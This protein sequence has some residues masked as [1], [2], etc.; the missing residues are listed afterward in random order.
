VSGFVDRWWRSGD[1]LRLHAR[2]YAAAG[3][4]ARLPVICLHGLTRNARDFEDLAPWIAASGRRV[5]ALDVRGRGLSDR[6][7]DPATYTLMVYAE[8]V[9]RLCL[10][11]GIGRSLF[12][13]TSMG[14]MITMVL[15]H[16]AP[17]LVGGAVLND[18]GP[19]IGVMGI[20]RIFSYAGKTPEVRTWADAAAYASMTNHTAF[21]RYGEADWLSFARRIFREQ[22]GAPVLDYDPACIS[23]PQAPPP[24]ARPLPHLWSAFERL[25]ERGPVLLMRGETSDILE[26]DTV[27]RMRERAPALSYA[28]VGGV[29][30]APMLDEPQAR[31]ALAAFLDL[32]P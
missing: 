2:D 31:A 5:L 19:E 12:V 10:N 18:I 13:G 25:T 9:V 32:A 26:P 29:G 28:E 7:T 27:R 21:P 23:P 22:S 16:E 11:L 1:G 20:A 4:E 8:D 14:G 17:D 3:G 30:H 15:A 6:A 24:G